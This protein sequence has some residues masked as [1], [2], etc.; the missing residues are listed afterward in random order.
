MIGKLLGNRYEVLEVV[1]GGG[2]AT[3]YKGRC[4][5]L[6]RFVAIKVLKDEFADDEEFVS[7]FRRES[8]A[9]A[10]LSHPNIVNVYDVGVEKDGDRNIHYIVMEYINGKTLKDIIREKGKLSVDETLNYSLQIGSALEDA[11][12]NNI[13]HRDIKPQNIMIT[14]DHRVKVTDFGIARA[15]TSATV[16]ATSD[17]LGSVHYFS[18]EQARGG[19]TDEK[20]D[21]YS[22]GIVMYEMITGELP[23]KGDS[24]ITVALKHVQEDIVP[25]RDLD[26]T[27]PKG[28][29]D[30][31]LKAVQK[32]QADRYQSIDIMI[33][34]L[35]K[36]QN[37]EE[38]SYYPSSSKSKDRLEDEDEYTRL[39]PTVDI[40]E[41]EM[42]RKPKK[43]K[44]KKS[45]GG[46]KGIAFGI[47]LALLLTSGFFYGK[48]KFG[49]MR[50]TVEIE[51]PKLVGMKEDEA[52][53]LIETKEL[54]F[55]VLARESSDEYDEGIIIFQDMEEGSKVK[56][57][58]PI[59]VKVS[60]GKEESEDKDELVPDLLG[61]DLEE[62]KSK[63]R[64]KDISVGEVK[65]E[66]SVYIEKGKI[67]GQS[68]PKFSDVTPGMT[69]DLVVS[70]GNDT[71]E[72]TMPKLVGN[73]LNGAKAIIEKN[74][75]VLGSVKE[76][77]SESPKG[78]VI[79]Q[80]IDPGN[81]IQKKTSVD[82]TT[83]KGKEEKKEDQN[84]PD[85]KP[86]ENTGSESPF[87][88]TLTSF[89]GADTETVHLKVVRTQDG[90]AKVVYDS[91]HN[92][93]ETDIPINLSG[94]TGAKFD[95]YFNDILQKSV[96]K[97]N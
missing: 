79:W 31:I 82:L 59:K 8:Q 56:K 60:S 63:L 95:I 29:E 62:A 55:G 50:N 49:K 76:E 5:L 18:P 13:V 91:S 6:D 34:D 84:E 47:L 85:P 93:S 90:E 36:L 17:V 69:M 88:I 81:S 73:N 25:P 1:G 22:L 70:S 61:L 64:E 58:Y 27:I 66:T 72:I 20:S 92:S 78:T 87:N 28:L 11:H 4:Q 38:V 54:E 32:R 53:E 14:N 43:K 42:P 94:K 12:K 19:Y 51:V 33:S 74:G 41:D 10:S 23:Y 37:R 96:V 52:K 48:Y 35:K 46:F 75:L 71:E 15:A 45:D 83:S 68:I 80:S 89:K 2:M 57:G 97:P 67:M 44:S 26:Y 24:P 21:I 39:I 30:V 40:E 65:E 3:V 86:E 16:T 9:A 77:E 7:K